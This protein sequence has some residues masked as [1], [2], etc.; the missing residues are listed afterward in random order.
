MN[1]I[2]AHKRNH[3]AEQYPPEWRDAQPPNIAAGVTT[4]RLRSCSFCGS[5]HPTDLASALQAG[6]TARWADQKY[7]WPH[8]LY[9][10]KIPNPHAGLL[11]SRSACSQPSEPTEEE[12]KRYQHWVQVGS[13]WR[14]WSEERAGPTTWGKF[15]TEHLQ[16]ATD[17]ER[18]V[19]EAAMGLQFTFGDD[20]SVA[21]KP[22]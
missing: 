9:V 3:L 13:I 20:G 19:I 2:N 8:K 14:G 17:E 10:D 11:E 15:Y 1:S 22:V 4:S 21:W 18:A 12:R 7:G 5:L 16:D 6:A